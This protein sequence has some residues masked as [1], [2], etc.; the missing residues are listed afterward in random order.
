MEQARR[1]GRL[2]V[3]ADEICFT[4]RAI[5]LCE[6][7]AKNTNLT[8]EQE[9]VYVSYRTAIAAMTAENGILLAQIRSSDPFPPSSDKWQGWAGESTDVRVRRQNDAWHLMHHWPGEQAQ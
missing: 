8:V 9:D 4:K 3:F 1:E 5:K 6:W 2:L 7:S